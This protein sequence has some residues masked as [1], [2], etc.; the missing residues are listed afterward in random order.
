MNEPAKLINCDA[1]LRFIEQLSDPITKA[2]VNMTFTH[3]VTTANLR[4]TDSPRCDFD[5][6]FLVRALAEFFAEHE[7]IGRTL[8]GEKVGAWFDDH[9]EGIKAP[10]A[11]AG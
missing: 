1:A 3:L 5:M 7:V 10:T 4:K 11:K 2:F 8:E 9:D 6:L